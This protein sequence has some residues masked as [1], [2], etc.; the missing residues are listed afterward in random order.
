MSE[1][2]SPLSTGKKLSADNTVAHIHNAEFYDCGMNAADG[3]V[4]GGVISISIAES[5]TTP[6]VSAVG[7]KF[8]KNVPASYNGTRTNSDAFTNTDAST[9]FS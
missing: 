8:E 1:S 3:T 5:L 4:C 7:L 9:I 6:V 2:C